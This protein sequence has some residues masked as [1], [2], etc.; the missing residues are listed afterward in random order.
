MNIGIA[1]ENIKSI[2]WP[3]IIVQ[4]GHGFIKEQN[5]QKCLFFK[6]EVCFIRSLSTMVNSLMKKTKM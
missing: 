4:V 3:L 2:G 5:V 1:K 6:K